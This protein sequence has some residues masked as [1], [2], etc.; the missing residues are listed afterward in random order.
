MKTKC[1]K[2]HGRGWLYDHTEG[3]FT[4]G[5]AYV[6]Q[7]IDGHF[8]EDHDNEVCPICHGKGWLE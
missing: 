3:I 4:F 2:C 6:L 5:I 7:F 8:N 1:W